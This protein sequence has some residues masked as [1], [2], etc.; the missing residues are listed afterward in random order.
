[1]LK[2]KKGIQLLALVFLLYCGSTSGYQ[3]DDQNN[4][5]KHEK[6]VYEQAECGYQYPAEEP[7][8]DYDEGYPQ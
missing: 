5:C 2:K 1:M 8:Q 3:P 7:N 6:D 4:Y